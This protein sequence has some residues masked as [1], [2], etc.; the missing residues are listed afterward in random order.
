MSREDA[1]AQL[2]RP[3]YDEAT[4][5]HDLEYVAA[6]LDITVDEL[7]GYMDAPN[8][9]YRDYKSQAGLYAIGSK[10]M[11]LLGLELGGKR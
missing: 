7:Q 8:K 9:D 1:L 11:R 10:I 3:A 2:S 4:I 6:K 5:R